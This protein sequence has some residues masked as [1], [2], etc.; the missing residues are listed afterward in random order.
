MHRHKDGS[1]KSDDAK[2]DDKTCAHMLRVLRRI[3]VAAPCIIMSVE[4]S[5]NKNFVNLKC[6]QDTIAAPGW[7]FHITNYCKVASRVADPGDWPKKTMCLLL[8]NIEDN[9][10]LPRCHKDCDYLV[11]GTDHH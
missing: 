7:S 8:F 1:P 11:P 2:R 3:A 4:N 10:M 5:Y 9:L 6:V